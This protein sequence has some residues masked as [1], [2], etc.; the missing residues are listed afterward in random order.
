MVMIRTRPNY[1]CCAGEPQDS[2]ERQVHLLWRKKKKKKTLVP[3]VYIKNKTTTVSHKESHSWAETEP[4]CSQNQR[5]TKR[6]NERIQEPFLPRDWHQRA[7]HN[8]TSSASG[9]PSDFM[10][11]VYRHFHELFLFLGFVPEKAKHLLSPALC[12]TLLQ[13]GFLPSVL[14][15]PD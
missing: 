5:R 8:L 15:I 7:E 13:P 1:L 6:F 2:F 10:G 3:K 14:L 4:H 12:F 9:L 11:M